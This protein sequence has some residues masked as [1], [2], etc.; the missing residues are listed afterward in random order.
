MPHFREGKTRR[1][2]DFL[3]VSQRRIS[4]FNDVTRYGYAV[5]MIRVFETRMLTTQHVD[6]LVEASFEEG[7][8]I[9]DETPIGEYLKEA[10]LAKEVDI[11]LNAFLRDTYEILGKALP[12]DSFIMDFFRCRFDFHNL[13]A[14]FKAERTGEEPEGLLEGLGTLELD[15]LHKGL[16]NPY[17][18]PWPYKE[19]LEELARWETPQELDTVIDRHYLEHRLF[20]ASREESPFMVDFARASIDL[21]NLK[22][23]IRSRILSK[24][25][26]FVQAMLARGGFIEETTL[27]EIYGEAPENMVKKL[28]SI[29]YYARLMELVEDEEYVVRLTEFDRRSDDQLMEM[30]RGTKRISVGVEPVF[31]YIRARE[32]E[33]LL[34]RLILVAKLHNIA[35]EAIEKM[36]RKLYIE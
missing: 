4:S 1:L 11:G 21:A 13:K 19:T 34:V 10:T 16:E 14:L 20:L 12:R 31:A 24:E 22:L 5:G 29:R 23:L 35:P 36:L 3:T 33:V 32:N 15:E 2:P 8:H 26:E 6:R 30:V 7:L 25:R 17:V 27:L 28:E 18:L 9:L